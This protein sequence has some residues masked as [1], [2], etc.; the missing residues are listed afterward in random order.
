MT[1]VVQFQ[2]IMNS[3]LERYA[4]HDSKGCADLYTE[5]AV[6]LSP[7]GPPAIGR[8][9]IRDEHATW[10]LE[11]E[12][13]KSMTVL[14][15]ALDGATGFCLVAYSADISGEQGQTRIYGASLN[16]LK[17]D[18]DGKWLIHQTSL[19]ELEHDMTQA[20]K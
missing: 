14:D 8:T 11:G 9:A 6:I 4:A 13:N 1:A 12:T 7:Y 5:D 3:Y 19:N 2:S 15:A 10:F 16:T 20:I 17:K 18:P